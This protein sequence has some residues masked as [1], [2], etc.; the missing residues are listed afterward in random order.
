MPAN[1]DAEL[2]NLRALRAQVTGRCVNGSPQLTGHLVGAR[3]QRARQ[4]AAR[5][6]RRLADR[7]ASWTRRT[8][9]RSNLSPAQ[10]G[11]PGVTLDPAVKPVARQPPQ[12][13]DPGDGR[14]ARRSRPAS[15]SSGGGKLTQHALRPRA[16]VGGQ[17]VV[18]LT[19]G[20]ATV[21]AAQVNCGGVADLALQCTSRR[22]VLIDVVRSKG[23]VRLLGAAR[24]RASPASGVSIRFTGDG[25]G[26]RAPEGR[27]S[28][29]LF[30]RHREAAAAG[31][32]AT[33]TG[34][35][36]R[37]EIGRQKSL[38]L[39]LARRMLVVESRPS[40]RRVDDRR[41][42]RAAARHAGPDDHRHA[43]ASRAGARVVKRFKPRASGRFR[44]TVERRPKRQ[45]AAVYR[46]QTACA[47]SPATR[48]CTPRSRSR[49]TSTSRSSYR[50]A[51]ECAARRSSR[52]SA[53]HLVI[54]RCWSAWSRRGWTS[55]A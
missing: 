10:L 39:K 41:P 7:D 49:G 31:G 38:R 51:H 18:D 2:L 29:G 47:S 16:R 24:P 25:Q 9:T 15:R 44:V 42:R 28:D 6:P 11:L 27:A 13:P 30:T 35:A 17:N 34:R 23:R 20:E 12:H 50:A 55:P 37:R 40:G 32:S 3:H 19:V 4:G 22:I 14:A 26:R 36:T 53:P 46:L 33:P 52:P 8:S 43:P 45:Q 48:G 54:P 1:F 5:G 21:G